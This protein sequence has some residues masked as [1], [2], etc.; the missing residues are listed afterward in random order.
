[1]SSVGAAS[2]NTATATA[3]Y[4]YPCAARPE[5]LSYRSISLAR[6]SFFNERNGKMFATKNRTADAM[7]N[8]AARWTELGRCVN[9]SAPQLG[10]ITRSRSS[11]TG[12]WKSVSQSWQARNW[13]EPEVLIMADRTN[14]LERS[15]AQKIAA[16]LAWRTHGRKSPLERFSCRWWRIEKRSVTES[17]DLPPPE[18][19]TAFGA[20]GLK[21][22]VA[23]VG[24]STL[25]RDSLPP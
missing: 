7:T 20:Y 4:W 19:N 10:Q 2:M 24:R 16:G 18:A 3:R 12:A 23:A 17:K 8:A 21:A 15:F 14:R 5:T 11:S 25:A 9:M 13:A 22:E 6:R 1:M